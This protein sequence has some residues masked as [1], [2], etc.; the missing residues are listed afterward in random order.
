MLVK[1]NLDYRFRDLHSHPA[2]IDEV[3]LVCLLPINKMA[4][5]GGCQDGCCKLTCL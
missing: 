5:L 4:V 3:V 1:Y 2:Q